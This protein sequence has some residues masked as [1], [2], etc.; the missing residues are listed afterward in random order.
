MRHAFR[1]PAFQQSVLE[2]SAFKPHQAAAQHGMP[3]ASELA[4]LISRRLEPVDGGT[5][6]TKGQAPAVTGG[7]FGSCFA[8]T[9]C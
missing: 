9:D 7:A 3:G 5:H 6:K 1:Q 4:W 8:D 2:Q